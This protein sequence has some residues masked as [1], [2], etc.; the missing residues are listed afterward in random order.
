MSEVLLKVRCNK[1]HLI[2]YEDRVAIELAKLGVDKS[3]SLERNQVTG[4]D[5]K[6]THA[7]LMGVGGAATI[8]I[9]STGGKSLE[10]KM[11]KMKDAKKVKE[12]FN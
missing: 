5:I 4:I 6:T 1:G 3:E 12:F 10:A 7:S 9:H 11:V 8:T 2:I